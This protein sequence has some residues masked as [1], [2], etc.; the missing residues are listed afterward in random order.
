V[1]GGGRRTEAGGRRNMNGTITVG[2]GQDG[3]T[4]SEGQHLRRIYPPTPR[5]GSI[6]HVPKP[7]TLSRP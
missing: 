1:H 5:D 3:S 7:N 6:P 4:D 2:R